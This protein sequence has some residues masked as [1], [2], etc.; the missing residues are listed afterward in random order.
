MSYN[1][2]SDPLKAAYLAEEE[3][4]KKAVVPSVSGVLRKPRILLIPKSQLHTLTAIKPEPVPV[5]KKQLVSKTNTA[6]KRKL[7]GKTGNDGRSGH[8]FVCSQPN[9]AKF[10]EDS[11]EFYLHKMRCNPKRFEAVLSKGVKTAPR[12]ARRERREREKE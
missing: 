10:F 7:V 5:K 4:E 12:Q 11:T 6:K 8:F 1:A 9:C 2:T 3:S